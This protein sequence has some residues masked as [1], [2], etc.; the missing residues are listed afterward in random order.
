MKNY[1]KFSTPNLYA[2]SQYEVPHSILP[3]YLLDENGERAVQTSFLEG[4]EQVLQLPIE[5]AT[6]CQNASYIN[7]RSPTYDDKYA[8][9]HYTTDAAT[10]AASAEC[11]SP[12]T[13]ITGGMSIGEMVKLTSSGLWVKTFLQEENYSRQCDGWGIGW[14]F[15][16]A[17]ESSVSSSFPESTTV[18]TA[19]RCPKSSAIATAIRTEPTTVPESATVENVCEPFCFSREL[20]V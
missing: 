4:T 20:R 3:R 6:Y 2:R 11:M 5:N 15:A 9:V 17:S 18:A 7:W 14:V 19:R 13:C 8:T 16:P 1:N 12:I 10:C